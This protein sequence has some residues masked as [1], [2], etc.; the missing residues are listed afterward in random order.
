MENTP[1]KNRL[2]GL[3]LAQAVLI[4]LSAGR[5]ALAIDPVAPLDEQVPA[6]SDEG[7]DEPRVIPASSN[8]VYGI[9]ELPG[10]ILRDQKFIW[11]RPFRIQRNDAPWMALILGAT[12]GMVATDRHVGQSLTR[13][14]PGNGYAFSHRAGQLGGPLTDLGVAGVFYLG[15]RWRQNENAQLTGLQGFQA[16]GESLAVVE[17]LKVVTQ[18]PRPAQSGGRVRIHNADGQF[19]TGGSSF[20][21]GHAA[22]AW[23][24]A[25][26][27]AERYR[28]SRWVP[29]TAYSLAGLVA[30]AR[31]TDRR[32]FPSDVFVASVVGYLIGRHVAHQRSSLSPRGLSHFQLRPFAPPDGAFALEPG[33]RAAHPPSRGFPPPGKTSALE[34]SWQF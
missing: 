33:A 7:K 12:A 25:A 14:P 4:L 19:F 15:G 23:A 18:R 27:V 10:E 9:R 8:P 16:L 17:V 22:A 1:S 13:S 34:L 24:F 2:R 30:A 29:A 3:I 20:P 31:I 28:H 21:S 26:V 5:D 6:A 32:H 11:L